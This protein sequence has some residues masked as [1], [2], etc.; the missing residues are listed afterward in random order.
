METPTVFPRPP[1]REKCLCTIEEDK[2]KN[3]PIGIMAKQKGTTVNEFGREGVE[4][5]ANCA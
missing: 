3:I 2:S 1:K 5:C 4:E